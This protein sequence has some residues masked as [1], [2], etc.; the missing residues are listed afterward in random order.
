MKH[1]PCSEHGVRHSSK[2]LSLPSATSNLFGELRYIEVVRPEFSHYSFDR[3]KKEE[4]EEG[5]KE[6][7]EGLF[8]ITYLALKHSSHEWEDVGGRELENLKPRKSYACSH[9]FP[10]SPASSIHGSMAG[11]LWVFLSLNLKTGVLFTSLVL[12]WIPLEPLVLL[13]PCK[14]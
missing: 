9:F 6:R 1:P 4:G 3:G 13:G 11:I 12:P 8:S 14:C 10:V 7:K 5:R 2:T